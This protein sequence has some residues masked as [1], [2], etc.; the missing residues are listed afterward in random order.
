[1]AGSIMVVIDP[2]GVSLAEYC[3]G[4]ASYLSLSS[5]RWGHLRRLVRRPPAFCPRSLPTLG[6]IDIILPSREATWE[7]IQEMGY[8]QYSGILYTLNIVTI[9]Y[10]HVKALRG[11][12]AYI[13][14][15]LYVSA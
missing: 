3:H 2:P 6:R 11:T 5:V 14:R 15:D 10:T 4:S 9:A 1:M 12:I 7:P 13:L 8:W